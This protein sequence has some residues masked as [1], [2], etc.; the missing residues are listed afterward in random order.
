[1]PAHRQHRRAVAAMVLATLMWSIAGVVTRHLH[2]QAGLRLVFWRSAFAALSVAALLLVRRGPAGTLADLRAGGRTLWLSALCWGTMFTAFML[3]LSLTSVAQT[4]VASSLGPL[5]AALLGRVVLGQRLPLRTWFA[6]AVAM[7]GV[8]GISWHNL[9]ADVGTRQ[10]L[11]LLVGLLVPLSAAGNWVIL[12]RA[13]GNLPLQAA[14]MLGALLSAAVVAVPG[15]PLAVDIHDLSGLALLGAV[16]LALPG[17]LVI[18]AA[19]RLAPA[20]VSLLGL[21][22]VVFGT[23]WAWLGAGETPS[24]ATLMGGALIL[25]ALV[26]NEAL[27]WLQT[28]RRNFFAKSA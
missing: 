24:A 5:F 16:Q 28:A 8:V 1:M 21:L 19:Q 2:D 11:G 4:L 17:A 15:A 14:P 12:R 7:A 9:Q 3:A 26:A 18:W 22:E 27:G 6:I 23:L 20:E 13:G 10:L 25:G